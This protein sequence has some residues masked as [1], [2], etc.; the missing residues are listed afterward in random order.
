MDIYYKT[1]EI[2]TL[3]ESEDLSEIDYLLRN[4]L[5]VN[6]VDVFNANAAFG[7][8]FEKMLFLEKKG[9]NLFHEAKKGFNILFDYKKSQDSYKFKYLVDKG[10]S[11]NHFN[12]NGYGILPYLRIEQLEYLQKNKNFIIQT[13][14]LR[15]MSVFNGVDQPIAELLYKKYNCDPHFRNKDGYNTLYYNNEETLKYLISVGVDYT[16]KNNDGFS[17]LYSA[18]ID[19]FKYLVSLGLDPLELN[20]SGENL[21]SYVELDVAKYMTE[22]LKIH[23][24]DKKNGQTSL[25]WQDLDSLHYLIKQGCIKHYKKNELIELLKYSEHYAI[26]Y[27]LSLDIYKEK[28]IHKENSIYFEQ[29]EDEPLY[30]KKMIVHLLS[31]GLNVN[32]IVNDKKENLLHYHTDKNIKEI[33][34]DANV[35]VNFI[36]K[37]S[38][39][40]LF[41]IFKSYN[42]EEN[43]S[44]EKDFYLYK[45]L[46]EKGIDIYHKNIWGE[47][48]L[49]YVN[50]PLIFEDLIKRGLSVSIL[51]NK[52]EPFWF[53]TF[54]KNL[55]PYIKKSPIIS[56]W[57]YL[58]CHLEFITNIVLDDSIVWSDADNMEYVKKNINEAL[59]FSEEIIQKKLVTQYKNKETILAIIKNL[60]DIRNHIEAEE[61]KKYIDKLIKKVI[62]LCIKD[63]SFNK[64][65][66]AGKIF[67]QNKIFNSINLKL[68]TSLFHKNPEMEYDFLTELEL[69]TPSHVAQ[70][71]KCIG[72]S[73]RINKLETY[74]KIE[75]L[76]NINNMLEKNNNTLWTSKD[77][78]K[79]I[80]PFLE[81][82]IQEPLYDYLNNN[83]LDNL[84]LKMVEKYVPKNSINYPHLYLFAKE[85]ELN[86]FKNEL[87]KQKYITRKLVSNESLHEKNMFNETILYFITDKTNYKI[88]KRNK[89]IDISNISQYGEDALFRQIKNLWNF[90]SIS[91]TKE[92]KD[93]LYY[94]FELIEDIVFFVEENYAGEN[95]FE[96]LDKLQQKNVK[97][98]DSY[99]ILEMKVALEKKKILLQTNYEKEIN[100]S[101]KRKRI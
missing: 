83:L 12:K 31:S 9:I 101:K 15:D 68:L 48:A 81:K 18:S 89:N 67:Y 46:I 66:L 19:S 77:D 95:I 41:K 65:W 94:I 43:E 90:Y 72:S 40:V 73:K 33:L 87:N 29:N 98:S 2:Q 10:L 14:N 100:K 78:L 47:T 55:I 93:M 11:F 7:A 23:P 37:H 35:N 61:C 75:L 82:L 39:N 30:A 54:N 4:G 57:E 45:K 71:I 44:Y 58:N 53:Y 20:K 13:T 69:I 34:I 51:N 52:G 64:K 17:A 63:V 25:Y 86:S 3:F 56:I 92:D 84:T 36:D 76:I 60:V 91:T 88:C 42:L 38:E 59:K 8:S 97:F 16:Q 6:S 5:D 32:N 99:A 1:P 70:K 79:A 85:K 22:D 50:N 26:D 74:K 62:I 80:K 28:E 24:L 49:F 21:F 27:L 96:I